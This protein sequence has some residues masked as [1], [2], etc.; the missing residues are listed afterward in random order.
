MLPCGKKEQEENE[1]RISCRLVGCE[2]CRYNN[3]T[4]YIKQNTKEALKSFV[5]RERKNKH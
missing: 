4:N 2:A 5:L 1:R 3:G